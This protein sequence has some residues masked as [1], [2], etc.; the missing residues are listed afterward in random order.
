MGNELTD[1][2]R[3]CCCAKPITNT[4]EIHDRGVN[5]INEDGGPNGQWNINF[6]KLIQAHW[7]GKLQR[8]RYMRQRDAHRRK[9]THFLTQD[10]YETLSK[11]RLVDL[12]LLFDANEAELNSYLVKK[13]H[14]YRTSGATYEG[15]WFGGFRH[16]QGMMHFRDGST[17]EGSWYLGRAHG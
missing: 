7:K 2:F 9:N 5:P 8:M 17:Y 6:I 12:Y 4:P 14:R 10:Q 13:S 1:P 15:Q 3:Q 11:L 16:G